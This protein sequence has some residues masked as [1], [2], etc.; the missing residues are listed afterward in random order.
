MLVKTLSE[1]NSQR[2]VAADNSKPL[3]IKF[4]SPKCVKC[5]QF[6]SD[7]ELLSE[8]WQ[9]SRADVNVFEADDEIIEEFGVT[10]LPA[11]CLE[12]DGSRLELTEAANKEA[13]VLALARHT[14][15]QL[16]FEDDF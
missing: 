15:P 7:V 14:T 1:L 2:I 16:K 3:L 4:F 5:P 12:R 11:F 10:R 6:G 9:F 8:S 13:L